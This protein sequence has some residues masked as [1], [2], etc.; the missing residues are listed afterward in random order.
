MATECRRQASLTHSARVKRLR[1]GEKKRF[2]RAVTM[3][4]SPK[5]SSVYTCH[6]L[7]RH[8]DEHPQKFSPMSRDLPA[9]STRERY[10]LVQLGSSTETSM[11]SGSSRPRWTLTVDVCSRANG[12]TNERPGTRSYSDGEQN[13]RREV[14][15]SWQSHM[16]DRW[17]CGKLHLYFSKD[18]WCEG[19]RLRV[20]GPSRHTRRYFGQA[21]KSSLANHPLP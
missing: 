8:D 21:R 15:P 16:A 2:L 18:A 12:V 5:K 19:R 1:Q 4:E 20:W 14:G 17:G 9:V 6:Y 13:I 3:Y 11:P 10:S 7:R